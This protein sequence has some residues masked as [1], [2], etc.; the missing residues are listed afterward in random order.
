[1]GGGARGKV[2]VRKWINEGEKFIREGAS[3]KIRDREECCSYQEK[4]L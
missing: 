3:G 4:E 2:R 1:M